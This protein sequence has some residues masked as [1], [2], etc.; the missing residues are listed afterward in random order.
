MQVINT[1]TMKSMI[2]H[3]GVRKHRPL[4]FWGPS[5]IGKS[6]A[7]AQC[8]QEH[9][10]ILVDI[11]LSQYE[12]IDLRGIPDIQHGTTVWN[13]PATLP[14][15]G[16]PKFNEDGPPI[17][18]FLDEINS[19]EP[20]T[21]AVAYQLVNDRRVGEHEL[22][23]NV[24]MIAAGNR[25]QDRGV[26]NRFPAPLANRFTHAEL[27]ADIK[28]W[29]VWAAK[30]GVSPTVIGFLN[31]R[32][33]LLHTFDPDKPA[34][35]FATPRTW[36]FVADDF[37]DPLLPADVKGAAIS[38][39]VGEGPG[40]ELMGFAE[41]MASIVPI[42]QIIA[43]PTKVPVEE[44]LDLQWAMATHVAGHMDKSNADPLHKFLERLEP[45][46]CVLAWTLAIN[47]DEEITDTNA[48]LFGYAPNYRSL[49]QN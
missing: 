2:S 26:V 5:G 38:G 42:E 30:A 28:P 13:L 1:T 43:N 21:A 16:N 4:V 22:M 33:E 6:E 36:K 14:F 8:A 25:E 11:R 34:K 27:I 35:V 12:S 17:I 45:E 3:L 20:S 37:A 18:L 32:S 48:F 46:M 31:F 40:V 49:F 44:R 24:T 19:A 7:V 23:N 9:G 15:K 47:R 29:S 10:A 39:S 41:I